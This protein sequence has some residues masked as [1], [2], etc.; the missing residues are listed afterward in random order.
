MLKKIFKKF[1][2][3]SFFILTF[4]FSWFFWSFQIFYKK[5]IPIL[6]IIGTFS[7]IICAILVTQINEGKKGIKKLLKPILNYKFNIVWYIFCLFSTALLS[8][9]AIGISFSLGFTD[10]SFNE[11]SKIYLIIPVFLF[12]LFFSVLGEETGWRGFALNKMQKKIT[13]LL[14]SIII[15]IIWGLWH[16]PLFF[17]EGNFHQ[18]IPIWLFLIQEIAL[19]IVITL[20]YNKTNKSLL[21]VHLFH[22]ASNTTLGIL[23]ILPMNTNNILIPLYVIVILLSILAISIILSKSLTINKTS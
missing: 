3:I 21:S 12:V 11:L 20:I 8:F 15:G 18:L 22:A 4:I 2:I 6:R 1:P 7:P 13:P 10:F 17:I 9:T 23:P 19:S 14:S 5:E 16:L